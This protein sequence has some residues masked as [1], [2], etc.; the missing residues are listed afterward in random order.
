MNEGSRACTL[1]YRLI[2]T[3]PTFFW[4]DYETFGSDPRRHRP[5]QFAGLRTDAELNE[6][7]EPVMLYCKPS[8]DQLPEPEACLLTGITPQHCERE[9]LLEHEFARIIHEQLARPGTVGA[10]YNSI[11]FDDEVTRFLLWRTLFDPYAREW[12][13]QCSRWDLFYVVRCVYAFHPERIQWPLNDQGLPSFKL[14]HLAQANHLVLDHAHDALSDVRTTVALARLIKR[15]LPRLWSFCLGLKD[16]QKVLSEIGVGR[17]FWHVSGMYGVERG[18]LAMVWPLAP[19]PRHKN[20]MILWDLSQDPSVLRGLSAEQIRA[21]LFVRQADLPEGLSRLPIKTL[22]L[23]QSPVVVSHLRT[24]RPELAQRWGIDVDQ[25]LRHADMLAQT[26]TSP[27]LWAEVYRREAVGPEP[28]VDED[29]YGA[30]LSEP[31]RR[32]LE[33]CRTKPTEGSRAPAFSDHRL[34]ELWLRYRARNFPHT[35]SNPEL[36]H[37]K[38]HCLEKLGDLEVY[39]S[40][41]EALRHDERAQGEGLSILHALAEYAQQLDHWIEPHH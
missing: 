13:N 25:C 1:R 9:G 10:G 30:F 26:E 17:A 27:A 6:I 8:P 18:C 34:N 4:H 23:N 41:L 7:G 22:H 29:L 14:E 33:R 3:E 35:L 32:E 39:L 16:K 11:K 37:W 38:A 12:Q 36:E 40:R 15:E 21:R 20:E 5:S 2:M 31:D 19:H 24:L 28:D